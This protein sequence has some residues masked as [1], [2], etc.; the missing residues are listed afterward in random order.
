MSFL[1]RYLRA[2]YGWLPLYEVRNKVRIGHTAIGLRRFEAAEARR[3]AATFPDGRLPSALVATILLTYKRHDD[4]LKAVDSALN[5][6]VTDHVVLVVDDGGG[7]PELPA[8][9]R[10][11]SVSLSRNINVLGVSRNIGMRL[12]DS[13]F[14][15]FLDDDNLWYPDHLET[16]LTAL[17]RDE[18][19]PAPDAVYTAMRRVFPDGRELDV[20]SVPF[21]RTVAM[22]DTFLDC[23][24]FVAKRSSAATFSRI[25]RSSTVAPKEDWELIY[26]LSRHHLIEHVPHVTV[27]YLVN[28]NSYWTH[29]ET[30]GD[31]VGHSAPE[32]A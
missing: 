26:R 6:T 11:H 22:N 10:L 13:R 30:D 8:H 32:A 9:P 27:D 31:S 29:W 25:R 12:T 2:R 23:N 24:C 16:A 19:Q 15:A 14:V 18:P 3:L 21:D 4:L 20:L 1:R 17:C 7:L 5:Q 28:P